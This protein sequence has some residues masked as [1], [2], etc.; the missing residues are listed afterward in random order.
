MPKCGTCE[1]WMPRRHP[2]NGEF[3]GGTRLA[4]R[5][6]DAG[7][8]TFRR[9]CCGVDRMWRRRRRE[10]WARRGLAGRVA[11]GVRKLHLARARVALATGSPFPEG[12]GRGVRGRRSLSVGRALRVRGENPRRGQSGARRRSSLP[13]RP[14][15]LPRGYAAAADGWDVLVGRCETPAASSILY[16]VASDGTVSVIGRRNLSFGCAFSGSSGC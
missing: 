11:R 10:G 7:A 1:G 5:Y 2:P 16:H 14:D 4:C 12:A 6:V 15:T 13:S 8:C 3:R 9:G